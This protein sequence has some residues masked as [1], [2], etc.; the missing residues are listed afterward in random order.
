MFVPSVGVTDVYTAGTGRVC[1]EWPNKCMQISVDCGTVQSV[2]ACRV[3][4]RMKINYSF[5]CVDQTVNFEL[6]VVW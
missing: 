1:S 2:W 4:K 3:Q 6:V 5:V